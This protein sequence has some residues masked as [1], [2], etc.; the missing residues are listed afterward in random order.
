MTF[1]SFMRK[2]KTRK[3]FESSK[4]AFGTARL[5]KVK[6]NKNTKKNLDEVIR[7]RK[8]SRE[9]EYGMQPVIKFIILLIGFGLL[10]SLLMN[11]F[12]AI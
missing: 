4:A 10:I 2:E 7:L 1:L 6:S 8:E 9:K 3:V 11:L 5:G 12:I